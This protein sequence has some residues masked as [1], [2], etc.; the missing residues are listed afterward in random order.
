MRI[1]KF[2]LEIFQKDLKFPLGYKTWIRD[3]P[4]EQRE[5]ILEELHNRVAPTHPRMTKQLLETV[6]RRAT[7]SM[8]QGRLRNERRAA[9]KGRAIARKA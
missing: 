1:E 5:Q 8:M 4:E 9:S 6:I 7:Y 2:I 3:T